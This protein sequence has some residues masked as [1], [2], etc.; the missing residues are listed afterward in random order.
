MWSFALLV[1]Q[2]ACAS[3][4]PWGQLSGSVGAGLDGIGRGGSGTLTLA[5]DLP[6]RGV[7]VAPT[8]SGFAAGHRTGGLFFDETIDATVQIDSSTAAR[9]AELGVSARLGRGRV[10]AELHLGAGYASTTWSTTGVL[11]DAVLP[12]VVLRD[13]GLSSSVTAGGVASAGPVDIVFAGL[14]RRIPVGGGGVHLLGPTLGVR[15]GPG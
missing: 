8:L 15:W 12:G 11:V 14:W 7:T 3:A 5:L 2:L 4:Q 6:V 13:S 9:G 10:A 1:S